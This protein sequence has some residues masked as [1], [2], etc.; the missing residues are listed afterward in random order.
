M[1]AASEEDEGQTFP[2]ACQCVHRDATTPDPGGRAHIWF[3]SCIT[4]THGPQSQNSG[5]LGGLLDWLRLGT[6]SQGTGRCLGP[7][8]VTCG[9]C[10]Q[11]F[12]KKAL[13]YPCNQPLPHCQGEIH[14]M[15]HTLVRH[16]VEKRL[17]NG[18]E[19]PKVAFWDMH[20]M[21]GWPG[22]KQQSEKSATSIGIFCL[23]MKQ[24]NRTIR[25][26]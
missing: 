22:W 12:P 24:I 20:R 8:N 3:F 21:D 23:I 2:N 10:V 25:C 18:H 6:A 13:E 17:V 5:G 14:V 15:R 9:C 11:A 1:K 26:K 19:R 16:N 7:G 4:Y